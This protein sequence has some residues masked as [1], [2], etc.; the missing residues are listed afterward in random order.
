MTE[1][2]N[3]VSYASAILMMKRLV[4]M[5]IITKLQMEKTARRIAEENELSPIYIQ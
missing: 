5:G 1:R 3:C 4:V 2:L